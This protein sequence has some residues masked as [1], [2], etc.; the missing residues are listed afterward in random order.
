MSKRWRTLANDQAL[1]R[2]LCHVH[3]WEWRTD[4]PVPA[5]LDRL[6]DDDLTDAVVHGERDEDE[7]MGDEE[8]DED[9]GN[10]ESAGGVIDFVGDES[11][12]WASMP[13]NVDDASTQGL[14][15]FFIP[16]NQASLSSSST[17]TITPMSRIM[18]QHSFSTRRAHLARDYKLLHQT[19]VLLHNRFLQGVYRRRT[20]PGTDSGGH[21][22]AVYCLWLWTYPAGLD[23]RSAPLQVLFTGSKD[24]SVREWDLRTDRMRR[25]VS[26]LHDSSVLS[27]CVSSD[28]AKLGEEEEVPESRP[29]CAGLLVSGG[30]DRR[31]IVWDLR[32]DRLVKVIQDH[33][34]SV[35][36]VRVDSGRLVTC[37]KGLPQ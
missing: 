19:H 18:S 12:N 20:L 23:G 34:D 7:G 4:A 33:L 11:V 2:R 3:C 14:S 30:S 1:W 8:E 28:F 6:G 17:S 25:V 24:R 37:S 9:E 21:S 22:A 31:V 35:L 36:C 15:H 16:I 13:M 10:G 29:G 5:S 27:L 26:G 32:E